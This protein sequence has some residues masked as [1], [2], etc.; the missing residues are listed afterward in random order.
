MRVLCPAA[1]SPMLRWVGFEERL[2]IRA[3][4]RVWG[5]VRVTTSLRRVAGEF[6]EG[7]QVYGCDFLSVVRRVH[8]FPAARSPMLWSRDNHATRVPELAHE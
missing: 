1:R 2:V 5:E 6:E 4:W 8:A 3:A 7:E